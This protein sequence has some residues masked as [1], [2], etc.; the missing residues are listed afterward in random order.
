MKY[1]PKIYGY[2]LHSSWHEVAL[3]SFEHRLMNNRPSRRSKEMKKS[4]GVKRPNIESDPAQN[5]DE[6]EYLR[7]W[8]RLQIQETQ[9]LKELLRTKEQRIAELQRVWFSADI[10]PFYDYDHFRFWMSS[11]TEIG[12]EGT[13]E[14]QSKDWEIDSENESEFEDKWCCSGSN[15]TDIY[16]TTSYTLNGGSFACC[17]IFVFD[18]SRPGLYISADTVMWLIKYIYDHQLFR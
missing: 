6:L 3:Q 1:I 12:T 5:V 15:V 2:P 17:G 14:S 4:N 13:D 11:G 10:H 9:R 8:K 7:K 16:S 18:T